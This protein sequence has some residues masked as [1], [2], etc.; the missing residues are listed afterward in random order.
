MMWETQCYIVANKHRIQQVA[1]LLLAGQG[2][3]KN[4]S[5]RETPPTGLGVE[6]ENTRLQS[7]K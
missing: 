3:K 4:Q 2:R 6:L 7:V 5:D 1:D